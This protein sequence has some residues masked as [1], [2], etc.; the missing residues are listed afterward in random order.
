[1]RTRP[2]GE[3]KRGEMA[4][5][6]GSGARLERKGL[7]HTDLTWPHRLERVNQRPPPP[8]R[9]ELYMRQCRCSAPVH[10]WPQQIGSMSDG[11]HLGV[12]TR[13]FQPFQLTN[14]QRFR[15]C[16]DNACPEQPSVS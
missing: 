6:P 1:M 13:S 16:G 10:T 11:V 5:D 12:E 9:E 15:P 2:E 8:E 3:R 7:A 4:R 14:L